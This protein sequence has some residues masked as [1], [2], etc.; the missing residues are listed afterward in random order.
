MKKSLG[1]LASFLFLT[2]LVSIAETD[3]S[4]T[5]R[6][7]LKIKLPETTSQ[8]KKVSTEPKEKVETGLS[9]DDLFKIWAKN[10]LKLYDKH[11]RCRGT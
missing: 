4:P 1:I 9:Q 6:D 5:L 10:N 11:Y 2:Q 3:I 7:S 8:I